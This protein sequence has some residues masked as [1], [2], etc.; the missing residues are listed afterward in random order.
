MAQGDPYVA[1]GDHELRRLL[2]LSPCCCFHRHAPLGSSPPR[3]KSIPSTWFGRLHFNVRITHH[4][5]ETSIAGQ[6]SSHWFF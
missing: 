3:E 6:V 1:K 5:T 2:L 4:R